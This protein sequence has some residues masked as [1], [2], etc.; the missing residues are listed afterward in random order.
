MRETYTDE[1]GRQVCTDCKVFVELNGAWVF[2]G[3]IYTDRFLFTCGN[4]KHRF[5][6]SAEEAEEHQDGEEAFALR[7]KADFLL[8]RHVGKHT[9]V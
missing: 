1:L 3:R 6:G 2:N 8:Q 7:D 9:S 5:V 4:C